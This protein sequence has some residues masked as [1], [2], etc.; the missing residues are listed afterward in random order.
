MLLTHRDHLIWQQ[1]CWLSRLH[2]SG[3]TVLIWV[4]E[5]C[6]SLSDSL[7]TS[8]HQRAEKNPTIQLFLE[9]SHSAPGPRVCVCEAWTT[10]GHGDI[11]RVSAIRE[12]YCAAVQGG[13]NS[14]RVRSHSHQ[15][16]RRNG[17]TRVLSNAPVSHRDVSRCESDVCVC[18]ARRGAV[19]KTLEHDCVTPARAFTR[20]STADLCASRRHRIDAVAYSW[21]GVAALQNRTA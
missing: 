3:D 10:R 14:T 4:P 5:S 15:L 8:Q 6:Q 2:Y 9:P 13:I 12:Y 19:N 18:R 21:N 20:D 7:S 1:R 16:A 17:E 11:G